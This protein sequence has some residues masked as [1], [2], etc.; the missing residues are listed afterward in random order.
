MPFIPSHLIFIMCIPF[1]QLTNAIYPLSPHFYHV[2]LCIP[3]VQL[4]NAIYPHL[5][6]HFY[7]IL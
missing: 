6:P 3:L 5:S 7:H 1:E 4:T 2:Q